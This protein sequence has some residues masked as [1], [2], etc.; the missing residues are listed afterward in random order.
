[1]KKIILTLF[2]ALSTNVLFAQNKT[3]FKVVGYIYKESEP[4]TIDYQHLTHAMFAFLNVDTL[5]NVLAFESHTQDNF[6]RFLSQSSKNKSLKK[7]IS[8][9]PSISIIAKN[10]KKVNYF[11]DNL[12]S[13]LKE[14][15]FQGVDMDW[16][17][18]E[19]K[20]DSANYTRLMLILSEKLHAQKFEFVATVTFTNWFGRWHDIK[21]LKAA[22]WV[23][24]MVYDATG[25]WFES[26]IGNHA[27]FD[28]LLQAEKYWVTRG[29]KKENLVMGLP[30]YGY[31]FPYTGKKVLGED[32]KKTKWVSYKDIVNQYPTLPDT[33]NQVTDKDALYFNGPELIKQKCEYVIKNK[34]AGVMFWDLTKDAENEKSLHKVVKECFWK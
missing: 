27:T 30:F 10:E 28:H 6:D 5:G 15:N 21:A 8:L 14:Y 13:F 23:Q 34:F 12:I 22:D 2:I 24:V 7:Y 32:Y 4:V 25:I 1:M 29:L 17:M 20:T 19:N 9:N 31:R 3:D 33:A 26:E 11:A 18:L 16:E